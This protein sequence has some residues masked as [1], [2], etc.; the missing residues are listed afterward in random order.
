MRHYQY[1][2]AELIQLRDVVRACNTSRKVF[3][4]E[5]PFLMAVEYSDHGL[6]IYPANDETFY[7]LDKLVPTLM[8]SDL[9]FFMDVRYRRGMKKPCLIVY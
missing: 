8:E 2:N 1:H 6:I 9:S 5:D 3:G 7:E 4:H